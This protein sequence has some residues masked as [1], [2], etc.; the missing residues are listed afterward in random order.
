MTALG[1]KILALRAEGKSYRY[2]KKEV[3]CSAATVA[4]W[5]NTTEKDNV[6]RRGRDKRSKLRRYVQQIKQENPCTDCGENYP[7]YVM[8]FDHLGDKSFDI[9]RLHGKVSTIEGLQKEIDKCEL[10]CANCH[11]FRTH[12][13][14]VQHGSN[15][16]DVSE[17]Y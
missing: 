13:R 14:M 10:V 12:A 9:S 11:R 1:E 2:I 6:S 7:Y 17:L 3:G 16:L 4:Y 15:S 8:D 5:C